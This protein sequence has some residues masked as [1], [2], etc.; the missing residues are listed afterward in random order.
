MNSPNGWDFPV[1]IGNENSRIH[2]FCSSYQALAPML[3]ISTLWRL[4]AVNDNPERFIVLRKR[5]VGQSDSL[6]QRRRTQLF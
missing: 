2:S 6:R 1:E 3:G 4:A 5:R